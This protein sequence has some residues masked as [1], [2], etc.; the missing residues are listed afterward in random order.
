LWEIGKIL[1]QWQAPPVF[2]PTSVAPLGLKVDYLNFL[3]RSR[4]GEP[5]DWSP[6]FSVEI[7]FSGKAGFFRCRLKRGP[8]KASRFGL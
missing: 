2:G 1:A 3:T 7:A 8:Q 4:D 5:V 6:G